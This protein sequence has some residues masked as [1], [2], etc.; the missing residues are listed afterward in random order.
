VTVTSRSFIVTCYRKSYC[1]GIKLFFVLSTIHKFPASSQ[2]YNTRRHASSYCHPLR[3]GGV[4]R[5]LE[6]DKPPYNTPIWNNGTRVPPPPNGGGHDAMI[7]VWANYTSYPSPQRLT[8][9][10]LTYGRRKPRPFCSKI[11]TPYSKLT[12]RPTRDSHGLCPTP[13]LT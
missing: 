10:L 11:K 12:H 1:G 3:Q 7:R 4:N 2:S 6:R 8:A 9:Y 13:S 5:F